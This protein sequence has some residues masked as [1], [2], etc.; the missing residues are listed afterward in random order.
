MAGYFIPSEYIDDFR[1]DL[2]KVQ[3]KYTSKGKFHIT[4]LITNEQKESFRADVFNII[5]KWEIAC[6]YEAC[7]VKGFF[8]HYSHINIMT[9]FAY[10]RRRNTKVKLSYR[11]YHESLHD[12]LFTGVFEKAL[13][14]VVDYDMRPVHI[15]IVSDQ[16]DSSIIKRFNKAAD[17]LLN[18]ELEY[19]KNYTGFDSEKNEVV[20]GRIKTSISTENVPIE[21]ILGDFS[22][23]NY[24]IEIENSELTSLADVLANSIHYHLKEK[25]KLSPCIPLN[26]DVAISGH[27]IR[28]RILYSDCDLSSITDKIFPP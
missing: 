4:E 23:I 17:H 11:E 27:S 7:Y 20:R 22:E 9:K 26:N 18:F 28:Q 3:Q 8:Q 14:F 15:K 12:L 5:E 10:D 24:S 6:V 16:L 1:Q 19:D 13:A 2:K 21:N 25:Q